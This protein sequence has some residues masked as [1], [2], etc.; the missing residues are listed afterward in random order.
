MFGV[1]TTEAIFALYV[2]LG[3]S[4]IPD[5]EVVGNDDI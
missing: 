5:F 2:C 3:V 4:L 1:C